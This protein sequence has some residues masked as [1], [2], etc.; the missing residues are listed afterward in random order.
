MILRGFLQNKL[1]LQWS[2]AITNSKL[3]YTI[4]LPLNQY[5][6]IME[7]KDSHTTSVVTT[8]VK[9]QIK[10]WDICSLVPRPLLPS[11]FWSVTVRKSRREGLWAF[12]M[13]V[14]RGGGVSNWKDNVEDFSCSGAG[15]PNVWEVKMLRMQ[16]WKMLWSKGSPS[17]CKWSKLDSKEGLGIRCLYTQQYNIL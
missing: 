2:Q 16:P 8:L 6:I 12:I 10:E 1:L 15:V 7:I 4:A 14:D 9:C 13:R 11:S 3:P 5:Y 17:I